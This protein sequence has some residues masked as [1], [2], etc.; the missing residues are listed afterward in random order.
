[1]GSSKLPHFST[2][3]SIDRTTR[4]WYFKVINTAVQSL[5]ISPLDEDPE[6]PIFDPQ[7][8]DHLL[9]RQQLNRF[10]IMLSKN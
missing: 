1:M 6:A 8:L 4:N 9:S 7:A 3:S 5:K 2:N 10:T